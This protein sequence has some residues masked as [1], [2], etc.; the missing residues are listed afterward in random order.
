MT[1]IPIRQD[2]EILPPDPPAKII[3]LYNKIIIT[4]RGKVRLA[5]KGIGFTVFALYE[6]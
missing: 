1:T 4:S 5:P 6:E 3:N 2:V